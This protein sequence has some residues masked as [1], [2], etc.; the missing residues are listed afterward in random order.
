MTGGNDFTYINSKIE[1]FVKEAIMTGDTTVLIQ[2]L[3]INLY[4]PHCD[5][6]LTGLTDNQDY[7]T[8]TNERYFCKLSSP[9]AVFPE[10][11]SPDEETNIVCTS[12]SPVMA[13]V[14]A[15]LSLTEFLYEPDDDSADDVFDERDY[16][17]D[18]QTPEEY[19]EEQH[20]EFDFED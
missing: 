14:K 16:P 7:V 20:V 11:S 2:F 8:G 4:G 18:E 12:N 15:A 13:I 17:E 10:D 19:E 3:T 6:F 9:M 5:V 1:E